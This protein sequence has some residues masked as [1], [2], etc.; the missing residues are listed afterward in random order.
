MD[1]DNG[2]FN[3]FGAGFFVIL[4]PA[5]HVHLLIFVMCPI[6]ISSLANVP[7]HHHKCIPIIIKKSFIC[8]LIIYLM[9]VSSCCFCPI[10]YTSTAHTTYTWTHRLSHTFTLDHLFCRFLQFMLRIFSFN[11]IFFT[12]LI[13]ILHKIC[14]KCTQYFDDFLFFDFFQI[15]QFLWNAQSGRCH[16]LTVEEPAAVVLQRQVVKQEEEGEIVLSSD[17]EEGEVDDDEDESP[18]P[19]NTNSSGSGGGGAVRRRCRSRSRTP[20][21]ESIIKFYSKIWILVYF[22]FWENCKITWINCRT[23][24]P[25]D[26]SVCHCKNLFLKKYF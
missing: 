3:N 11:K 6:A 23:V 22:L 19:N 26:K 24:I 2:N 8:S 13:R 7:H 14:C 1:N 25:M 17:D 9:W 21:G 15:F 18:S 12:Q 20:S 4:P 16:I 10:H 5:R